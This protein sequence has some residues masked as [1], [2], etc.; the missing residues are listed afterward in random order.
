MIVFSYSVR[1]RKGHKKCFIRTF[2]NSTSLYVDANNGRELDNTQDIAD[3]YRED[4]E[5]IESYFIEKKE[6]IRRDHMNDSNSAAASG[7]SVQELQ[8]WLDDY[9][10][11]LNQLVIQE[12]DAKDL[13]SIYSESETEGENEGE[14]ENQSRSQSP[15]DSS[16][17]EQTD[18]SSFDPFDD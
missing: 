14:T 4:R 9:K 11:L 15:Q 18:F 1:T 10:D 12:D 16:D 17:V 13:A 7:V 5:G 3:T 8:S 2:T 6:S